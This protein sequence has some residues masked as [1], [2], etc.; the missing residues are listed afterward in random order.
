MWLSDQ[1]SKRVG[2]YIERAEE[3]ISHLKVV[4]RCMQQGDVVASAADPL[5]QVQSI[6]HNRSPKPDPW[7]ARHDTSN[8]DAS[9][10]KAALA[11][12]RRAL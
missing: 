5:G 4:D 7:H 8:P 2:T 9:L 1:A 10:T 11:V 3:D 12:R 6:L